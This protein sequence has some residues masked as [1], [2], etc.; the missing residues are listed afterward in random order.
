MTNARRGRFFG[1]DFNAPCGGEIYGKFTARFTDHFPPHVWLTI[2][3]QLHY[4][5]PLALAVDSIF[6]TEHYVAE[7]VQT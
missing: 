1:G 7:N 5:P 2:D 6:S 4:A 3:P